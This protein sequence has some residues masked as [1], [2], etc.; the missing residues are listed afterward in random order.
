MNTAAKRLAFYAAVVFSCALAMSGQDPRSTQAAPAASPND[1]WK[2]AVIYEVYPRSFGDSNGDGMGDLNGI[3]AHLDYLKNLGVDA[4]WM[5]P[6]YPSPQVDFGYDVS[7][8]RSVDSRYGTLADFDRM[9]SEAKK[10][11]IK[12]IIDMVLNHSSDQHPWFLESRSS[13]TNP[14][15]DWYVWRDGKADGQPPNNWISSFGGSAW[16]W[17]PERGQYYYHHYYAEQPDFNWRNPEVREALSDMLRFWLKRGV[18]GFRLDGIGNLYEDAEFRDEPVLP[19]VNELGD[20]NLKRIYTSGLPETT[21]AYRMLR[22]LADEFPGSV[23]VGQVGG[24][25]PAEFAKAYGENNDGLQ[26]PIYAQYGGG[27]KL[28]AADFRRRLRDVELGLNGHVPLLVFDSHDR[29]RSWTR[30][31]D[32]VHDLDIAKAVAT[33]LLA[34][35][36]AA[37]IYYGQELGMENND[38]KRKED[39]QDPVGRVGWP[40]NKGRDGERTPMQWTAG[41]NAGFNQGGSAWL[42]VSPSFVDRN[43]AT[44]LKDPNSLF[45]YYKALISLRKENRELRE[46]EFVLVN[47]DD[48]NIV[49]WIRK[50]GDG[51]TVLVALNLSASPHV[52]TFD[53]ASQGVPGKRAQTL[54]SSFLTAGSSVQLEKLELPPYGSFI[55]Q[56]MLH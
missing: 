56:V 1:W 8:Y 55:G 3:T 26:L 28:S 32:G 21:E 52:A 12:V 46:G 10:R 51:T 4:I 44:E 11:N 24:A 39:V 34:P 37:L 38:P 14:K 25:T 43:A 17:V 15:A 9:V 47:E 5:T 20:P 42:P 49:S 6:F 45:G 30:Y 7:D 22:K 23:L 13:R 33:L 16:K 54:L 36:D 31:A 27:A 41:V 35:R 2:N 19:G 48:E 40:K 53:L 50:T 29:P 18:S